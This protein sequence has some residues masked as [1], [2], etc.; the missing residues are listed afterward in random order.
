MTEA[1]ILPTSIPS[2]NIEVDEEEEEGDWR[3]KV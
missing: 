3:D 2:G 1:I